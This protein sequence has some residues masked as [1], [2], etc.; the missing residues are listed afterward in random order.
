MY[1]SEKEM[2]QLIRE[3]KK[4]G[5]M[6]ERLMVVL[7]T[8]VIGINKRYKLWSVTPEDIEDFCQEI[9]VLVLS[10]RHMIRL[11]GSVFNY[12]TTMCV[13]LVLRNVRDSERQKQL[14]NDLGELHGVFNTRTRR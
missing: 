8:M 2:K 12:V 6:S 3:L 7:Q 5:I 10:K 11:S 13:N 4:T 1:T 14:A 9:I